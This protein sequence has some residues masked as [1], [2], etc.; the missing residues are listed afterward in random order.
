MSDPIGPDRTRRSEPPGLTTTNLAAI[1][2]DPPPVAAGSYPAVVAGV[3]SLLVGAVMVIGAVLVIVDALRLPASTDPLG[4]AAFPLVIGGLL[5]VL[6]GGLVA[7]NVRFA[8]VLLRS[9]RSGI[10]RGQLLDRGSLLRAALVLVALILFALVLP[11]AG[12]FLSAAALY[13][14][15]ALLLGAPRGWHLPIAAVLIAG[16]VVLI[17]DRLIGLTLPAGPWGF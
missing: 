4:P 15:G 3:S 1:E 11:F 16:S 10:A 12:F 6:G 9:R 2:Q 17:F 5:G 13:V 8:T 14:V 7:A